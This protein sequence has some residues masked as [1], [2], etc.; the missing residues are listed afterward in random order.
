VVGYQKK[1]KKIKT[2]D[3]QYQSNTLNYQ[4]LLSSFEDKILVR[5]RFAPS[6]FGSHFARIIIVEFKGA[7]IDWATFVAHTMDEN[8]Y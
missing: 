7:T 3:Y 1:S 2:M 8:L 4:Q 5:T 6:N